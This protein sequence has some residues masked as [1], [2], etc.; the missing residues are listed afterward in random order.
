MEQDAG[1]VRFN[2]HQS[3]D[4]QS[5]EILSVDLRGRPQNL[6]LAQGHTAR[7]LALAQGHFPQ[8]LALNQGQ[9]ARGS[10]YRASGR[11]CV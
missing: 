2:D 5:D 11:S 10:L 9:V 6:A 4:A 1:F 8:N 7:N 3:S